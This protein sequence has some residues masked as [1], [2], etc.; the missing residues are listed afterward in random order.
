MNK[1]FYVTV[2]AE[3]ADE[4]IEVVDTALAEAGLI[5]TIEKGL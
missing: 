1:S 5:H 3:D 4:A 2:S